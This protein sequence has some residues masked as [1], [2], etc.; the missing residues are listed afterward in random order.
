MGTYVDKENNLEVNCS[1]N[2]ANVVKVDSTWDE[3]FSVAGFKLTG[4]GAFS[5]NSS[6]KDFSS[7]LTYY[8]DNLRFASTVDVLTPSVASELVVASDGL[9]FGAKV[10][11]DLGGNFSAYD[12]GVDYSEKGMSVAFL[13]KE[14]LSVFQ[15]SY[16][17]KLSGK[18]EVG[19]SAVYN[20]SSSKVA[21]EVGGKYKI[22]SDASLKA[23]IDTNFK[24]TTGYTQLLRPGITA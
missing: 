13:T 5:P 17:S 12:L 18:S 21:M 20:K 7:G 14:K 15:A 3:A 22:D 1:Y 8:N 4:D 10:N 19:C 9:S 16:Y 23:K 6:K 24:I 11:A 2:S